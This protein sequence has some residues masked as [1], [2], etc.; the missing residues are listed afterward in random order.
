MK[1]MFLLLTTLLLT[2]MSIEHSHAQEHEVSV[3][4]PDAMAKF[5]YPLGVMSIINNKCYGCHAPEAQGD[6]SKE[7]LQW[8]DLQAMDETDLLTKMDEILEVLEEG[9][10]PP[11]KAVAKYPQ[12]ELT[13][14]EV[15]KLKAWAEDVIAKLDE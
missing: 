12:L 13:D 1:R 4:L 5:S 7:A 3:V 14:D 11:E 15:A 8:V 10:M 6:K 2:L 9:K